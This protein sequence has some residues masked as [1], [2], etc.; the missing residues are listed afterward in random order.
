VHEITTSACAA[1][2]AKSLTGSS[3]R[4]TAKPSAR[5]EGEKTWMSPAPR[6]RS[7]STV[8]AA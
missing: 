6:A 1:A 3:P 8:R 2:A 5:P 7:A 4:C